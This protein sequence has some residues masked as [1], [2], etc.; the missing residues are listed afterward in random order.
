VVVLAVIMKKREMERWKTFG[1]L[2]E[3]RKQKK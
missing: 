1:L 2:I 3:F